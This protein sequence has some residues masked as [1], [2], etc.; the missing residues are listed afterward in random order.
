MRLLITGFS[1]LACY[2]FPAMPKYLPQH[3]FSHTLR[4]C[5]LNV[6]NTVLYPYKQRAKLQFWIF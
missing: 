4:I 5:S 2:C 1:L 6:S 3:T